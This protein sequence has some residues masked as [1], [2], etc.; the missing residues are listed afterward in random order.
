MVGCGIDLEGEPL[1]GGEKFG[2][3]LSIG[4]SAGEFR[5]C[6]MFTN[7]EEEFVTVDSVSDEC[8][9]TRLMYRQ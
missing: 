2:E 8:V 4:E 6:R 1:G 9:H 3:I 5:Y 7:E